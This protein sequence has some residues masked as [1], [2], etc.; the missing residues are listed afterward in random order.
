MSYR[1]ILTYWDSETASEAR[2]EMAGEIA[3]RFGGHLSVVSFGY[4]PDIPPYAFGGTSAAAMA[5]FYGQAKA[6]AEGLAQKAQEVIE[7]AG[8]PGGAEPV[9]STYSG[10][11]YT[12]GEHAKFADLVVLT[13]PYESTF[14]QAAVNLLEGALFDGDAATLVLPAQDAPEP[15]SRVVIGWNGSREAL[16]AVRRSLPFLAAAESVE[17]AIIEPDSSDET[18]GED[19]A[20]M[21]SRH[22]IKAEIR[23]LPKAAQSV[24]EALRQIGRA[25]V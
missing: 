17:I 6:E 23:L 22:G 12:F 21:L 25:H 9:V 1:T 16:R 5:D 7:K 15:G 13:Q 19:L 2:V 8:V 10:L 18:P 24:S 11:S 3:R 14:E 4:E 20:L